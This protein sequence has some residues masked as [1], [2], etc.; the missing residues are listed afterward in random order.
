[1]PEDEISR[2]EHDEFSRRIDE[3]FSRL[4]AR[5][6]DAETDLCELKRQ[7]TAIEKIAANTDRIAAE[8][9]KQGQRLEKLE[10]RDAEKWKSLK[11]YVLTAIVSVIGGLVLALISAWLL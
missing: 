8:Q 2:K 11:G 7:Y 3:H 4:D 5:M 6:E 1:M 10:G 9:E